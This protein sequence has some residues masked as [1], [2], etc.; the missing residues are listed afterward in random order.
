MP[1]LISFDRFFSIAHLMADEIPSMMV[2]D[3]EIPRLIPDDDDMDDESPTAKSDQSSIS[4]DRSFCSNYLN[5]TFAGME[6]EMDYLTNRENLD[7]TKKNNPEYVLQILAP[8]IYYD[9]HFWVNN[10]RVKSKTGDY[11]GNYRCM[12]RTC[13]K[14]TMKMTVRADND[15]VT[16]TTSTAFH[17]CDPN[18][19]PVLKKTKKLDRGASP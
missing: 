5:A 16:Q 17:T 3:D 18:Y 8:K 10:T 2:D 12:N 13:C 11:V 7:P 15:D 4:D 1:I 19:D 6:A 9:N 14:K